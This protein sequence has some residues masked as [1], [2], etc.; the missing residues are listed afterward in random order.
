MSAGGLYRMSVSTLRTSSD[1]PSPLK[2]ATAVNGYVI[3][4][5]AFASKP[6]TRTSAIPS[7]SMSARV[8]DCQK[9]CDRGPN[10]AID[11]GH[12]GKNCLP[13]SPQTRSSALPLLSVAT[14]LIAY[15]EKGMVS[16]LE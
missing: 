12:P 11:C 16:A 14:T 1:L 15:F 6:P 13:M 9:G 7:P 5:R 8:G 2:S 4:G 3:V 10:G